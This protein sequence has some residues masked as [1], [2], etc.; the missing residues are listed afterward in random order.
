MGELIKELQKGLNN[1]GKGYGG[2]KAEITASGVL[3]ASIKLEFVKMNSLAF[4]G[5]VSML[6][7]GDFVDKGVKGVGPG[8]KN[9]SS[10]YSFKNKYVPE[11]MRNALVK[12]LQE[13]ND[14]SDRVTKKGIMGAHA[15]ENGVRPNV[16]AIAAAIGTIV[17]Q[18][19]LAARPFKQKALD[20][21][22]EGLKRD[23]GAALAK[24]IAINIKV[25][26]DSLKGI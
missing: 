24:D 23:L 2:Y 8:N 20:R 18:K 12:W 4:K 9:T 11:S 1:Q 13:K 6:Y 10:P 5:R 14:L 15:D 3:S 25:N 21:I 7:Y 22:V 19:G 17:K 26:I 16:N